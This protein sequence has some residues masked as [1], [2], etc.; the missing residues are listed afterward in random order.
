MLMLEYGTSLFYLNTCY[1]L[2]SFSVVRVGLFLGR[3]GSECEGSHHLIKVKRKGKAYKFLSIS[4]KVIEKEA[5]T[6]SRGPH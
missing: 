6:G 1:L 2:S 3:F 5:F 4:D